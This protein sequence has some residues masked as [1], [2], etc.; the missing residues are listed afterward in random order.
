[1]TKR[2]LPD[3]ADIVARALTAPVQCRFRTASRARTIRGY[4]YSWRHC[5]FVDPEVVFL[6]RVSLR[7][8][9]LVFTTAERYPELAA[10]E[11]VTP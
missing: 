5:D 10:A 4:F 9:T 8:S 7:G 3:F 6:I 11:S 2:N 1:M